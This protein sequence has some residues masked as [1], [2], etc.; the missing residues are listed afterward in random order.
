MSEDFNKNGFIFKK[1]LFKPKDAYVYL[2][3]FDKI[4]SQ[5]KK[6]NENINARW[7]SELTSAIEPNDS[8]VI[9]THNIQNYSSCM[10]EMIQNNEFLDEV[11]NIIGPDIVLHHT[12]L[13]EK[14]SKKGAAFPLH[15]DWSYFPTINNSMIA[16]VI[17]LTKSTEDMGCIRIVPE[18]H[19]L[20]KIKSSDGHKHISNIHDK[21]K[22][23]E[24]TPVIADPGDVLFFHCCSL[25]GSMSN[26]S[27]EPRKSI[28]VQ[29]YSGQDKIEKKNEH[30]NAQLVLR[31]FNYHATRS[32]VNVKV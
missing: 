20:G 25:H 19:Q 8:L 4:V 11:E 30:T 21:Y 7:G 15:Q 27:A 14:P 5:L 18:S 26:L 24:A 10:L 32:T 9:H 16:A 31:G 22:L 3:E 2:K 1:N 6:S 29:L 12:K 13:F 28:L 23:E 17:H